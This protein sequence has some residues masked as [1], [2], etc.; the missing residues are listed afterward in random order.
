MHHADGDCYEGEWRED[1]A[2]GK[3]KYLHAN[4][5]YYE[6]DWSYDKQHGIGYEFWPDGAQY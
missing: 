2:H 4:N 5:A 1:K 3:G 6:G